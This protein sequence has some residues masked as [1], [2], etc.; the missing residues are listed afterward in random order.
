MADFVRLT[1]PDLQKLLPKIKALP[2]TLRQE[3]KR[4]HAEA[5]AFAQAFLAK[6]PTQR[7]GFKAVFKSDRQRR[8][9][10]WALKS[11]A[12]TVPYRRTGT[13]GRS[14]NMNVRELRQSIRT[15]VYQA[16]GRGGRPRVGDDQRAYGFCFHGGVY[17][18]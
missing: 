2:A 3:L 11:G 14:W 17:S 9:F 16:V 5:G 12:I 1:S 6:Y 15:V 4:G 10:F 18:R 7:G 8:F 13:L